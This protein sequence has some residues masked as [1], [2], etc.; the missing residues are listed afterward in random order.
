[1][2]LVCVDEQGLLKDI[3]RLIK[4]DIPIDIIDGFE[5][6]PTIKAEKTGKVS[7]KARSRKKQS[8]SN[9]SGKKTT[10]RK[11]K[12]SGAKSTSSNRY[13]NQQSRKSRSNRQKQTR[14]Q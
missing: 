14:S 11:K 12:I 1:M 3:E 8:N 10:T 7:Q 5:P 6:D 2:S 13:G 4:R 9:N